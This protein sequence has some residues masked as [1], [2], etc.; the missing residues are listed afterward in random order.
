[1]EE[2]NNIKIFSSNIKTYKSYTEPKFISNKKLAN[3]NS[4]T[5]INKSK[6]PKYN[7]ETSKKKKRFPRAISEK[8]FFDHLRNNK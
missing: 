7:S 4:L 8:V 3:S 2:V 6:S 5:E 1:M